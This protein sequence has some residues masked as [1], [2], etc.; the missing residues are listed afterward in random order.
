MIQ[1]STPLLSNDWRSVISSSLPEG[2]L[3]II[4][5]APAQTAVAMVNE[6]Y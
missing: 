1:T 5:I 6:C 2:R 4:P 3:L